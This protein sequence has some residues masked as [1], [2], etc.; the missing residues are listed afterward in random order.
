LQVISKGKKLR[1]GEPLPNSKQLF[2][3]DSGMEFFDIDLEASDAWNVA[4]I[5]VCHA[6]LDILEAGEDL[7]TLLAREF[8]REPSIQK[9]DSRR[10]K[11]KTTV[12][13]GNYLGSA[14]TIAA[15]TGLLVI[16][17]ERILR[18][19]FGRFPEVARWQKDLQHLVRHKQRITNVFGFQ[20]WFFDQ[21]IPTLMQIAAAWAPQCTTS[22]II[23]KGMVN[24]RNNPALSEVQ[25]LMQTHDSLAGQYPAGREDLKKGIVDSCLI[26]LPY[27]RPITIPVD[28]K[29]SNVSWGEC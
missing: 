25:V 11:F 1:N 24:I 13:A 17:V 14:A 4:A 7:Y 10:Q 29:T 22:N 23:N 6:L 3:P 20:R 18:Y 26:Y 21:S 9:S 19:Y 2:L 12:H 15:R 27:E 16:D 8:F 28:L 5:S